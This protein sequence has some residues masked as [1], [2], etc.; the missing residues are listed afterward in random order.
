GLW[1]DMGW[2]SRVEGIEQRALDAKAQVV[3][4]TVIHDEEGRSLFGNHHEQR[5]EPTDVAA[6]LGEL[7]AVVDIELEGIA[8]ARHGRM[9]GSLLSPHRPRQGLAQDLP[10]VAA[11]V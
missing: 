6:M 5:A 3:P 1:N 7:P 11:P 8:P 9:N 4:F 2:G 10:V